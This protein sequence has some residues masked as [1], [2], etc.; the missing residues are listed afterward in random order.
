MIIG[1]KSVALQLCGWALAVNYFKDVD[2]SEDVTIESGDVA[3]DE[4]VSIIET[5][6][7][8]YGADPP[9]LEGFV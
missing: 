9:P 1:K 8:D 5:D 6:Y 4:G 7:N 3:C 2:L